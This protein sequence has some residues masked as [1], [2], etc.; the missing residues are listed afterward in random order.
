MKNLIVLL[1]LC[2]SSILSAQFGVEGT[3]LE[4]KVYPG[5]TA[6]W[7]IPIMNE[8]VFIRPNIGVSYSYIKE[9]VSLGS[10][11]A[12]MSMYHRYH[13]YKDVIMV[14]YREITYKRKT[15]SIGF[16]IGPCVAI[17]EVVEINFQFGPEFLIRNSKSVR[18]VAGLQLLYRYRNQK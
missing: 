12:I 11:W 8:K 13:W 14:D 16:L 18:F 5:I 17:K 10:K 4:K 3:V 1:L 15:N 9:G 2:F 7:D 6:G